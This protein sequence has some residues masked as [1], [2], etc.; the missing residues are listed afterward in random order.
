MT[1]I[2]HPAFPEDPWRIRETELDLDVLAQSESLFALSNGHL[3]LRGNLDEGEPNGI[4]GTYLN[5]VFEFRPR[6]YVEDAYGYPR[7]GQTVINVTNGKIMRLL[8]DDEPLDVRYGRLLKHERTLDLRTGTLERVAEWR[9]PAGQAVRVSSRRLV[10]FTQRS[11]AAI[12]YEVEPLESATRI[13]LQSE[14][15]A[16]ESPGAPPQS[17]DPRQ[18]AFLEDPLQSEKYH[19][20]DL[21]AVLVHGT[22]TSGLRLAAVMEHLIDGPAGLQAGTECFPD[23]ARVTLTTPLELGQSLRVVKFLAYGWSGRRSAQ[24]L[25]DQVVA[26]VAAARLAGWEGLLAEQRAYLEEFW[27]NSDVEL[28]G[29]AEVQQAVRFSLFHVLQAGARGE[30]RP[31]PAKGLTGPGYEGHA[32]WDTEA[33]V[34]P[35]LTCT[36]PAAAAS[37]LRWRQSTLPL[38]RQNA[39]LLGLPGAAFPWRTICGEEASGY[40]PASTAAL[41][42]NA[43]IAEAAVSYVRMTGDD[44][45]EAETGLELLVETARLWHAIGHFDT[46]HRFRIDGVTGPDEYSALGDDNVYT[47]LM[48]QLNLQEAAEAAARH[49]ERALA[50]GVTDAETRQ[51]REAVASMHIPYDERLGVHQQAEGFTNYQVW[52]FDAT[53]ADKYPLLLHFPYFHLYRTQVIKQ[54]DL[55][56]AM[57]KRGDAFTLDQKTRNFAYYERLTVRDSSLS[58]GTEAVLAAEIG[59]LELAYDYLVEAALLDLDDLEH[60]TR[61]GIHIAAVAG[62]WIALVQG[63]GGMRLPASGLSFAP[64]L[65][66]RLQRLTFKL[67]Y[68]GSRLQVTAEHESATYTLLDGDPVQIGHHGETF[69]LP[70]GEPVVRSIPPAPEGPRPTQPPGREPY[71]RA[72]SEDRG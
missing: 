56:L 61:D 57:H 22:R 66:S 19:C 68:R 40:W 35:M 63:F 52:D 51:W 37:A 12:S 45:F 59:Q 62:A 16:N 3:G 21:A 31:I 13:V 1:M 9:S 36:L 65:P 20:R 64:R 71:R 50:L 67:L 5:S 28:E 29:D 14:L 10:S 7:S 72:M 32:F 53:P 60:N 27:S 49:P 30:D 48:A 58:D 23:Y 38:A 4:P 55:V 6:A 54:P 70:R 44:T 15:L 26:A 2:L 46:E 33:F 43:D 17:N 42:I 41:H 18:A 11:I 24:A 34:V 47:N 25:L 69:T 8:V 39:D